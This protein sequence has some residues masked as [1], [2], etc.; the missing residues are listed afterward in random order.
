[1][2]YQSTVFNQLLKEVPRQWFDRTAQR[3][4]SGRAKRTLSPWGH[5]VAMVLVQLAGIRDLRTLEGIVDRH[6]G[7]LGIWALGGWPARP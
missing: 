1:M 3:H 7:V 6:P 2:Q 5:M 4:K